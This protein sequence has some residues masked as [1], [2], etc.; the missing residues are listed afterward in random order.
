[1][2]GI[3]IGIGLIIL[4]GCMA[5]TGEEAKIIAVNYGAAPELTNETWLNTEKP[6]RLANLRGNVVLIHMW[7]FG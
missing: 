4:A 3:L 2:R 7:T 5:P 1:M 6:L